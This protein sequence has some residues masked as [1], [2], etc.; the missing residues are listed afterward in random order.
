MMS[1]L[2]LPVWAFALFIALTGAVSPL[3]LV[4]AG[5]VALAALG[6]AGWLRLGGSP[7]AALGPGAA[8]RHSLRATALSFASAMRWS[9]TLMGA[10]RNAGFVRVRRPAAAPGQSQL[11]S[12]LSGAAGMQTVSVDA[13]GLLVHVLDESRA[14]FDAIR[15]LDPAQSETAG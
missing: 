7:G 6:L 8:L 2:A 13:D 3:A 14:P 4:S 15:S 5:V 10:H 12:A 11:A 9:M 1:W